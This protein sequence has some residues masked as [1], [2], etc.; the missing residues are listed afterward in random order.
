MKRKRKSEV[1]LAKDHIQKY[2]KLSE[3]LI[4]RA[5]QLQKKK[6][7]NG[8]NSN[9][10]PLI[11][12]LQVLYT[13][14]MYELDNCKITANLVKAILTDNFTQCRFEIAIALLMIK[15]FS[16]PVVNIFYHWS[17]CLPFMTSLT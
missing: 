8:Q 5:F 17:I 3:K 16:G 1:K 7:E 10:F 9:T 15:T 14:F 13:S 12:I 4:A 11:F 6:G 2:I